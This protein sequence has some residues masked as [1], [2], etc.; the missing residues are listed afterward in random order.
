MNWRYIVETQEGHFFLLLM[1]AGLAGMLLI[2]RSSKRNVGLFKSDY[3]LAALKV[4][5]AK[6]AEMI[7]HD[8]DVVVE[9][10]QTGS[11]NYFLTTGEHKILLGALKKVE[12]KNAVLAA[13]NIFLVTMGAKIY[14]DTHSDM[15]SVQR[16]AFLTVLLL[17]FLLALARVQG[18]GHLGQRNFSEIRGRSAQEG[19]AFLGTSM[20]QALMRDLLMK[21][22]AFDFSYRCIAGVFFAGI[23]ILLL[24]LVGPF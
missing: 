21:E 2:Y 17:L 20:Q 16:P 19:A 4:R 18:N 23:I 24:G 11:Q 3:D 7:G 5:L 12:A 14:Y 1:T 15:S 6:Y 13:I 9:R 22:A 8:P 10:N